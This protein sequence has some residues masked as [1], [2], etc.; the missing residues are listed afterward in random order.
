[1]EW[2]FIW[3]ISAFMIAIVAMIAHGKGYSALG[4]VLYGLLI[5]PIALVHILIKPDLKAAQQAVARERAGRSPCPFC[6]EP[7][8]RQAKV[9][10]HCQRD[11]PEG[12]APKLYGPDRTTHK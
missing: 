8:K 6:A 9:C 12:W 11:L 2:L 10:P 4:W 3:P 5:W 7:V 1:M